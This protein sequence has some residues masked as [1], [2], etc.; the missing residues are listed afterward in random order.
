MENI[1]VFRVVE[2]LSSYNYE[3]V[4]QDIVLLTCVQEVGRYKEY[5]EKKYATAGEIEVRVSSLED[6][7]EPYD[8]VIQR[9]LSVM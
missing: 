2:K 1:Y 3:F 7:L 8:E 4:S 9:L 6:N 5:L